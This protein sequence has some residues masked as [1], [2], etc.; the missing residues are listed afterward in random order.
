MNI[1]VTKDNVVIDRES[2]NTHK[3]EYNVTECL[4]T[5]S[6]EYDDLTTMA[7]FTKQSSGEMYQVEIVGNRCD[8][9][10]EIFENEYEKIILGVYGYDITESGYLKLRQSPSPD[11][12]I[13]NRG[14]F[15]IGATTPEILTPTQYEIY[16]NALRKALQ[17]VNDAIQ[18]ADDFIEEAKKRMDEEIGECE[19]QA[20]YAKEQGD[21]AKEQGTYAKNQGDYAKTTTNEL[22]DRFN[23]GEFNGATFTPNVDSEGNISWTNDKGLVNPN[24]QNIRGPQGIPG[25][26]GEAFTIYKRYESKAEMDADLYYVPVGKY[27]MIQSSVEEVDNA[28]MYQRGETS[29]VFICDFSG[30]TGIQGPKG[31]QGIQGIQ[32]EQGVPG[33]PGPV[34]PQG[35][36]GKDG[37]DGDIIQQEIL[38]NLQEQISDLE[39]IVDKESSSGTNTLSYDKA[40]S[41]KVFNCEYKGNVEQDTTRGI[42]LLKP[43]PVGV[44]SNINLQ[45]KDGIFYMTNNATSNKT[46]NG[47]F[48]A[49]YQEISLELDSTKTYTLSLYR[50]EGINSLIVRGL[51]TGQITLDGTNTEFKKTFTGESSIGQIFCMVK[52]NSSG[53][54]KVQL[55]EGST[56]TDYEPYTNGASPN[57]DYPQE[58]QTL[59]G[60]N[61]FDDDN[62]EQGT[63]SSTSG[64]L[65]YSTIRIRNKNYIEINNQNI[66][67]EIFENVSYC[68]LN[69]HYYDN[70][71]SWIK[72]QVQISTIDGKQMAQL[73]IPSN[74]KYIKAVIRKTN[75]Y[76][77][78]PSE[79]K[80]V[81][82]QLKEG[83]E[84]PYLPYSSIGVKRIGKTL[85]D[86]AQTFTKPYDYWVL[87]VNLKPNTTYTLSALLKGTK[88]TNITFAIVP[89]GDRYS[90][91]SGTM[92]AVID[93][94]TGYNST[95]TFTTNSNWT[96][97]KLVV[98]AGSQEI[99]N[100]IFDNYDIQLEQ[101]SIATD[102]EPYQ[103]RI[104]YID[105]QGQELLKD[106]KIILRDNHLWLVK[107]WGKVVLDGSEDWEIYGFAQS[108][109]VAFNY[110][111][112]KII[113]DK[114]LYVEDKTKI[115]NGEVKNRI[116]LHPTLKELY[117]RIDE[118]INGITPLKQWLSENKP[119]LYYEMA[120]PIEIDLGES[121]LKTISGTNNVEILSTIS[122]TSMSETYAYDLKAALDELKQALLSTG[123]NV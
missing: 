39:G 71:Y 14:S 43:N 55:E 38:D 107:N 100:S 86:K 30:A 81:K 66:N 50:S 68:F 82:I 22:K 115:H 104:D 72:S 19:E 40:K 15:R 97:P 6:E 28:K 98:Y 85:F 46:V 91:F 112:G 13:I 4:F 110:K 60:Y 56:A 17:D 96:S 27:V 118:T 67:L 3:G 36:P 11:Q 51:S 57:P 117:I 45:V 65:I 69:V 103:E 80:Q 122:P 8:I 74:A 9:P 101:N 64:D 109:K 62:W 63:I 119:I 84:K 49:N 25:P 26:Q 79:M 78:T 33:E 12:F 93:Y 54:V 44:D 90:D 20:Q 34:G 106:D 7:I 75:D 105:L 70:S 16:A 23:Q 77:I 5:F 53:W 10:N 99:L 61:L 59:K 123:A 92:K 35:E 58:V 32:G 120:T 2:F 87:P 102:Y 111:Y 94:G 31:D 52:A 18:R 95:K 21:Y 108:Y 113:S 83:T 24:T 114:F 1:N 116:S 121:T 47:L 88:L 37:K 42:N 29:W 41:Y 89:N 73:K 48:G 76:N